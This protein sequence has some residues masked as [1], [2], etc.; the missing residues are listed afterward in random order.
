MPTS[1]L[2]CNNLAFLKPFDGLCVGHAF[3]KMCQYTTTHE[4]KFIGMPSASIKVV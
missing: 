1:I 3:S 2:S 4:K